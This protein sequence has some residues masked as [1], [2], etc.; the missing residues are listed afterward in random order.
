MQEKMREKHLVQNSLSPTFTH[1]SL[2]PTSCS[3]CLWDLYPN[4][5]PL[6][7]FKASAQD[8]VSGSLVP[9][10]ESEIKCLPERWR[11][12]QELKAYEVRN[13][14]LSAAGPSPWP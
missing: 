12:S 4:P 3:H 11:V 10:C 13:G 5:N 8:H 7:L 1:F 14:A 9:Y 2:P 6:H